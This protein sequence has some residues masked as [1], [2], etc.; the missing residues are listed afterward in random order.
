MNNSEVRVPKKEKS[1][2]RYM[3]NII[4]EKIIAQNKLATISECQY[5]KSPPKE[6]S[7]SKR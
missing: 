1:L 3:G 4:D 6:N 5:G 2:G 7:I